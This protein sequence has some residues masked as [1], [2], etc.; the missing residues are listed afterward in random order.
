M[1]LYREYRDV[2]PMFSF[3]IETER[4]FYLAN[5]V[6]M[7]PIGRR[8]GTCAAHRR[9]G[10]GH[11]PPCEVRLERPGHDAPRC[12]R[13]RAPTRRH[14]D[15]RRARAVAQL[16]PAL[17]SERRQPCRTSAIA[18]A[19]M[20]RRADT[21]RRGELA[22]ETRYVARGYRVVARNWRCRLGELDLVLAR[23]SAL[24]I[25]EVK[26]R[27]GSR[28]GG[29]YEAVDVRKRQKLRALAEVFLLQQRAV[30]GVGPIRCGQRVGSSPT[31]QPRSRSSRTPSD[32][33]RKASTSASTSVRVAR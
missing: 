3:V 19:V 10:V 17:A 24:V 22:A 26:T 6:D 4:R 21:G 23:G 2:L 18:S 16:S 9:V 33:R 28:Y 8:V 29:G 1:E 7:A 31:G 30:T 32:S 20:D 27:R 15:P 14:H 5:K 11:V 12:Q 13:R 25:C